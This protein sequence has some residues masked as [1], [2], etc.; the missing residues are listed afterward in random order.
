MSVDK[1]YCLSS[2]LAFRYIYENDK[3]FAVGL[4]HR[5]YTHHP[6]SKKTAVKSALEIDNALRK[7]FDSLNGKKLG[8]MLSGGMDS[9]IL[10][11]YMPEGSN[12]YTFRFLGGKFGEEELKRA[13]Q[14]AKHYKLNLKYI[15]ISWDTVLKN[16]VPLMEH[17][18]APVHSIEP[19]I[20]EAAL[21]AKKDGVDMM[22]IG[23]AADYVFGG[24]DG[25]LSKDWKFEEFYRRF[26]YIEPSEVLNDP[27]DLHYIFEKYRKGDYIDFLGMMDTI[28]IDE[29]YASYE[30]AFSTS[31]LDYI[32]PY[33][34][35]KMAEPLDLKRIR[36]GDTKYLIRD[37]FRIKYPDFN[38]PNKIP[39]PRPVDEYFKNWKG[40]TRPEFKKDIDMSKFSGN[41]KWLLY[42]LER[43][44]NLI[45]K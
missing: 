33:E 38:L 24:M 27:V 37:L 43:F 26:I 34:F 30:N 13:E 45:E 15:D 42:C 22:V 31:G 2:F 1:N 44:L 36:S 40:P 18:N 17:K 16:L 32:D 35:L 3:D 7:I 4:K 6:D 11:S 39:M 5:T 14:Y 19:Q 9:A 10:A 12:A 28:T 20:M 41:Q 29:S 21:Q 25:L 8:M 23:D